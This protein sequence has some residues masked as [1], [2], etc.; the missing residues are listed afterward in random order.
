MPRE[1]FSKPRFP[2]L[3]RLNET[4]VL[5]FVLTLFSPTLAVSQ[6][7]PTPTAAPPC[8]STFFVSRNVYSSAN[9]VPQ[10]FIR[11]SLCYWGRYALKIYNS[12]G[13]MVKT[14]RD[15]PNQQPLTE[16]VTWDGTNNQQTRVADGVYI[17]LMIDSESLHMAKV[18]LIR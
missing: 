5:V 12:S 11:T 15:V 9:D 18:V 3:K 8:S 10:L 2:N 16:Q 17:I 4:W 7:V 14:L 13:E 1:L 6:P